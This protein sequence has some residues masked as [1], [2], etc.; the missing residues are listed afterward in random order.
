MANFQLTP[1]QVA[2][3]HRDGYIIVK[4]FLTKEE[5]DKLYSIAIEDDAIR[6]NKTR[7]VVCAGQ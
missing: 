3:Y 5:V 7:F 4:N 2:G 1:Q 6:K